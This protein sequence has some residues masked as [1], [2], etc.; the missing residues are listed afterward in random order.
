MITCRY[1]SGKTIR[2]ISRSLLLLLASAI[3]GSM[4]PFSTVEGSIHQS[5]L[6][7]WIVP[8]E[9]RRH[10]S[11]HIPEVPW[12]EYIPGPIDD[13]SLASFD[14][15]PE[16]NLVSGN[17]EDHG[18]SE[19]SFPFPVRGDIGRGTADWGSWINRIGW[20]P[21]RLGSYAAQQIHS[22]LNLPAAPPDR[23]LYAP[24]QMAPNYTP[25]ESVTAYWRYFSMWS[26]GRAWGVWDH[27]GG[28]WSVFKDINSSFLSKYV[29]NYNPGAFYFTETFVDNGTTMVMLYNFNSDTW[30]TQDTSTGSS[31]WSVGWTMWETYFE[32]TCPYLPRI[33]SGRVQIYVS[34]QW[35]FLDESSGDL[36]SYPYCDYRYRMLSPY[37]RWFVG[38]K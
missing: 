9:D 21:S 18:L 36:L 3:V 26:T 13:L 23:T 25:L 5:E 37:K 38:P 32:Q 8:E 33:A 34:G 4:Y 30:E 31:G 29:R 7:R 17:R 12:G 20:F 1:S 16:L 10:S 11:Y 6:D 22:T 28:G 24:T 19:G 2:S 14:S 35:Q 15:S 27:P